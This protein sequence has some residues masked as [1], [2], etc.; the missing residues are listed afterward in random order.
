MLQAVR[1]QLNPVVWSTTVQPMP[2]V[3]VAG[4]DCRWIERL[5]L[6]CV[7]VGPGAGHSASSARRHH[8]LCGPSRA[9]AVDG[10]CGN[11]ARQACGAEQTSGGPDLH[12][13][14]VAARRGRLAD[15]RRWLD[16][17]RRLSHECSSLYDDFNSSFGRPREGANPAVEAILPPIRGSQPEVIRRVGVRTTTTRHHQRSSP[18]V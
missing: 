15:R 16:G 4:C 7:Q 12:R 13:A 9:H 1:K 8:Q 10:R 18:A 5:A 17:S 14:L 11:G 2:R 6:R 3:R